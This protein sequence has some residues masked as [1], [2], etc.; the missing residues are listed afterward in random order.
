MSS[1]GRLEIT[2]AVEPLRGAFEGC[3]SFAR[4]GLS[5]KVPAGCG[6]VEWLGKGPF[7][8]YQDRKVSVDFGRGVCKSLVLLHEIS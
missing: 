7:E 1:S 5:M 8:C 2:T 4:V 6:H 3:V